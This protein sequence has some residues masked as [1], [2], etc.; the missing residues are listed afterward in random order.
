MSAI[1]DHIAV[2]RYIVLVVAKQPP[3]GGVDISDRIAS[4]I[5]ATDHSI[6]TKLDTGSGDI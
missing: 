2:V 3:K 6:R 4:F 5:R 1:D